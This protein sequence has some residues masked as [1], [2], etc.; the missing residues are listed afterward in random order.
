MGAGGYRVDIESKNRSRVG[1]A[2]GRKERERELARERKRDEE[3]R[4]GLRLLE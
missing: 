2:V 1:E 3:R 4:R